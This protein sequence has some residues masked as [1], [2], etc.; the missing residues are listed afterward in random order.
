M[1]LYFGQ[2][3]TGSLYLGSTKIG[4]AYMGNVKVYE[5]TPPAMADNTLKFRFS[6]TSYDPSLHITNLTGATW[7]QISAEPNVWLWDASNVVETDWSRAFYNKWTS[8]SNQVELIEAGALTKPTILA[9]YPGSGSNYYGLFARDTYLISVCPL[10]IPN[11]YDCA[12]I[13]HKCTNLAGTVSLSCPS[14]TTLADCFGGSNTS[15]NTALTS[16]N[17]ITSSSLVE[18][19]QIFRG[20]TALQSFTISTTSS[21]QNFT[22]LCYGCTALQT[23]PLLATNA[24][25]NV[26][27]MFNN[28]RNVTSGALALYTQMSTQ[29]TPPYT[30]DY[31]FYKCGADTVTGA[32]ELAQIPSAWGGTGS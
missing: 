14:A 20:C 17:I 23:V 16:A 4:S 10:S 12:R 29:T 11:A 27:S 18:A 13:F 5:S 24:A 9:S 1:P 25:T 28:C 3:K 6:D 21:V 7:T 31:C 22:A 8:N 19:K 32:A 30:H 15:S 2:D 26:Q